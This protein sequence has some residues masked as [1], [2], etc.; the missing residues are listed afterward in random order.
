VKAVALIA[1][2]FLSGCA[3]VQKIPVEFVGGQPDEKTPQACKVAG[4]G[5]KCEPLIPLLMMLMG[6]PPKGHQSAPQHGGPAEL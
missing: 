6:A 4:E 3:G 5:L 2:L 1:L